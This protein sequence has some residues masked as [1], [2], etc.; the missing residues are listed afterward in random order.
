MNYQNEKEQIKLIEENQRREELDFTGIVTDIIRD[1]HDPNRYIIEISNR[2]IYRYLYDKPVFK[3]WIETDMEYYELFNKLNFRIIEFNFKNSEINKDYRD[4]EIIITKIYGSEDVS[5]Q[6]RDI[7][8]QYPTI[9]EHM[10]SLSN[11]NE[12]VIDAINSISD[13]N[14]TLSDILMERFSFPGHSY[15]WL[16]DFVFSIFSFN[17]KS[18]LILFKNDV[19][20]MECFVNF[21]LKEIIYYTDDNKEYNYL[22]MYRSMVVTIVDYLK[23]RISHTDNVF[24]ITIVRDIYRALEN[25]YKI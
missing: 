2:H 7:W 10:I 21:I 23:E 25:L 6:T 14:Q 22:L 12:S 9:K 19:L 15:Y 8:N 11:K 20:F 13:E 17:H 18:D 5:D 4:R 3:F 1:K 24:Q 16:S